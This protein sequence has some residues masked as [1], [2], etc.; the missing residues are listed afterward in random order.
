MVVRLHVAAESDPPVPETDLSPV[1]RTLCVRTLT[2]A[3]TK[4]PTTGDST[5]SSRP[6]TS[7][8]A[9]GVADVVL[10]ADTL[11]LRVTATHLLCLLTRLELT[12]AMVVIPRL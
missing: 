3:P 5:P 7:P 9:L 4:T 1:D 12:S 2:L 8:P 6:Q 10:G 11:V